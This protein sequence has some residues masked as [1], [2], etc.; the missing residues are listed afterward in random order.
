MSTPPVDQT[1]PGN[2]LANR[3]RT[4]PVGLSSSPTV[5][6]SP[7]H[8]SPI[9]SPVPP[10]ALP[11]T[12]LLESLPPEIFAETMVHLLRDENIE[13][14][15]G[16]V[17][18][19]IALGLVCRS[20]TTQ[21]VGSLRADISR[22][23]GAAGCPF[24]SEQVERLPLGMGQLQMLSHIL[25]QGRKE[26]AEDVVISFQEALDTSEPEQRQAVLAKGIELT[27]VRHQ[28]AVSYPRDELMEAL[29][30]ASSA[31]QLDIQGRFPY[32]LAPTGG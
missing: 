9:V 14:E 13:G 10:T 20:V 2:P 1:V 17:I 7:A 32:P 25:Q 8:A 4:P 6:H 29:E 12:S 21:L 31:V 19:K 5:I 30:R 15:H 16:A 23:L 27:V 24:P 11:G 28:L 22:A 3:E 18:D 26:T